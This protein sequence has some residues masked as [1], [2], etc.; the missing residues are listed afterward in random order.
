MPENGCCNRILWLTIKP[1]AGCRR[2]TASVAAGAGLR[3]WYTGKELVM[4][5]SGY[6][7]GIT[8]RSPQHHHVWNQTCS[9]EKGAVTLGDVAMSNTCLLPM[10]VRQAP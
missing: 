10:Q 7:S 2:D 6:N 3:R 1:V 9:L 4:R 8:A 5:L